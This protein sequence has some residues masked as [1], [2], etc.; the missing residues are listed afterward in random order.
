MYDVITVGSATLD[1]FAHANFSETI[2]IQ[3][4]KGKTALLAF[5]LGAKI[6]IESLD[7][8]V[9]GGGTNT[10][11]AFSRLGF[12]T[13]YIGKLGKGT[14]S[15]FIHKSLE[16]ENVDM[17]C[18]HGEGL[19][20]YSVVLDSMEHE[21]TI[22]AY[23]GA[24]DH[25]LSSEVPYK[26]LSAK[27]IYLSAM[28][29]ESYETAKEIAAFAERKGISLAFN[30]SLYLAE[31]GMTYLAPILARTELLVLNKEEAFCLSKKTDIS[32]ALRKLHSAGAKI[33]V[34]TDGKNPLFV[35]DGILQYS[36][37]PPVVK[38]VDATGAGD[39]FA[40][41]FMA[42]LL[43]KKPIEECIRL[44]LANVSSVLQHH[45]AKNIL[46][47]RKELFSSAQKVKIKVSKKP[48]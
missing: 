34:I 35:F 22:L 5:P 18:V 26:K 25:L 11:V 8:T 19:A 27:W 23:K 47:K 41:T 37:I 12:K 24:N 29:G 6:I 38:V 43:L 45:G 44:S 14:N 16:K 4:P 32:E 33:I 40:A 42:G 15:D 17:L 48:L 28:M 3:E 10:A 2:T 21:R 7:F 39:A 31:K 13:G 20:G 46:L 30:P 36:C 1:V 9:G